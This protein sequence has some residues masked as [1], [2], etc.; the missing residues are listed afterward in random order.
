MDQQSSAEIIRKIDSRD[1]KYRLAFVLLMFF[2]LAVLSGVAFLQ[3]QALQ[4]FKEQ[5]TQRAEAIEQRQKDDL[6]LA[7]R[8]N[9]YIQCIARFFAERDRTNLTLTDLDN[10]SYERS[11]NPVPGVD[12]TPIIVEQEPTVINPNAPGLQPVTPQE[13]EPEPEPEQPA[14]SP[15]VE[16]IGIPVC[17]PFTDI[18]I[19][20]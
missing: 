6:A 17:V 5:S 13:E 16:I 15:P 12:T 1:S 4:E 19:R 20:Q 7:G 18:C 3:F 10:C 11:G 14:V 9:A 8:T 2:V